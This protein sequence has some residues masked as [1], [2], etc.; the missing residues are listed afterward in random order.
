MPSI[1]GL[2]TGLLMPGAPSNVMSHVTGKDGF[3]DRG[4]SSGDTSDVSVGLLIALVVF[5]FILP[6]I[7][8]IYMALQCREPA[9]DI[10]AAVNA[11]IMYIIVRLL[12]PCARKGSA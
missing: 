4:N 12:L 2:V 9:L 6:L 8:A 3:R 5:L 7:V 1:S 10:L 11:P